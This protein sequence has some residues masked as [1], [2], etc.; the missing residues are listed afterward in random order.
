VSTV[1]SA[2][3][4]YAAPIDAS[5][6]LADRDGLPRGTGPRPRLRSRVHPLVSFVLLQSWS[7]PRRPGDPAP[8]LRTIQKPP[9]A[10]LG[11]LILFATSAQR[12]HSTASVPSS[13]TFRPQRFARSR[14]LTPRCALQACFILLPRPGFPLQG[15][16]PPTQPDH[17]VGDP[18]L[19]AVGAVSLPPVARRRQ[20]PSRRPQGV[21]PSRDPQHRPGGL[22]PTSTRVPSCVSAPSGFASSALE[23]S[24]PPPP[25]RLWLPALQVAPVAGLQRID[26]LTTLTSYP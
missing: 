5:P 20:D 11:V 26:R 25:L 17:L 24:L 15:V 19:R 9:S 21:A 7:C 23:A 6:F 12:V 22:A 3:S 2:L 10:F 8:Y 13:P 16:P 4:G 14:R 18:C 1:V